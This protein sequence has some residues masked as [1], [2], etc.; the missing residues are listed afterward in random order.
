M[1]LSIG[2][3]GL[4]NV[5]KSTLFNAITECEIAAEN[6][7]FCT[8]D[9][10]TGIVE[11]PDE[12][13]SILSAI[14][15]TQKII[16]AT[17]EFTDIAGLVKGASKGEGLGNKF[18]SHIRETDAIAHVV[19][20]F[21]D[22]N[23]IH[24]D[25]KVDP[26][27]DAE[28]INLEL[29]LADLQVAEKMVDTQAKKAKA[30]KPEE[31]IRLALLEKIK[32]TLSASKPVRSIEC[33]DEERNILKGFHF[34]T[35]K[36][37]IFVANLSEAEAATGNDH[38]KNLAAYANCAAVEAQLNGFDATE[39]SEFLAE[40]GLNESGI[41]KLA[42]ACF[43]LLGLH[44]YLTTG[45]K[46]TRAWTIKK[47]DTAPKAAGVIHT[48]FEKGFIRANIAAFD[49]FVACNG[50]KGAKEKGVM[51]QEGKEYIMKDGDVVE[52]LFNT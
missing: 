41:G 28:I 10:N 44:T 49:D 12:R 42:K 14:S 31:K 1:S 4:P 45:E 43:S 7:P 37:V 27:A 47:G 22:D 24:V 40:L 39:K 13:L 32:D 3:V 51:R 52:F 11:I 46:E 6:F 25:G 20:C 15:G 36:K 26:V 48:D 8:I 23:I 35:A 17:I 18:L 9:P 30:G 5:G 2:I 33:S 16:H 38:S 19:R 21:E 50:W 29:I 34:I